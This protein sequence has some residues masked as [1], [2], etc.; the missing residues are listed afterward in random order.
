MENTSVDPL[1]LA[2][3][4]PKHLRLLLYTLHL[5]AIAFPQ[6]SNWTH[7]AQTV[8]TC[9]SW[10]TIHQ[11]S[12][13]QGLPR[14]RIPCS[15]PHRLL[16]SSE[17]KAS[18]PHN[19]MDSK[20]YKWLQILPTDPGIRDPLGEGKAKISKKDVNIQLLLEKAFHC[21][22]AQ[23]VWHDPIM[24][25]CVD[26]TNTI[27]PTFLREDST[28]SVSV[29]WMHR[30]SHH[31]QVCREGLS[32][33]AAPC[34]KHTQTLIY[35]RVT[36][37]RYQNLKWC[38]DKPITSQLKV[39]VPAPLSGVQNPLSSVLIDG[40]RIASTAQT[41]QAVSSIGGSFWA[42]NPFSGYLYRILPL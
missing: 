19:E 32:S 27:L 10:W 33:E 1:P 9:K 22:R 29:T 17:T 4:C 39:E 25:M 21:E 26:F 8:Q 5:H 36:L 18:E 12:W 2:K 42:V 3:V 37:L 40:H 16:Y 14:V 30:N 41:T 7:M 23:A 15:T 24:R 28:G 6:N 31:G 35:W 34:V 13:I 11:K 20:I 38:S